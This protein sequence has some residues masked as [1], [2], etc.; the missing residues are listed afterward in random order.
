MRKPTKSLNRQEC[1]IRLRKIGPLARY[2]SLSHAGVLEAFMAQ[3][4]PQDL[5]RKA[6]AYRERFVGLL[7]SR[8]PKPKLVRSDAGFV[9]NLEEDLAGEERPFRKMSPIDRAPLRVGINMSSD[10]TL[11]SLYA[12]RQGAILAIQ[13]LAR[14]AGRKVTFEIVYGLGLMFSYPCHVRVG[15]PMP[16]HAI[17]GRLA[18]G[19]TMGVIG[20]N[21]V[22]PL[23]KDKTYGLYRMYEFEADP[24]WPRE[25]DIILDRIEERNP[26]ALFEQILRRLEALGQKIKA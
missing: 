12:V 22:K 7:R 2:S 20:E 5:N 21:L 23:T 17:M 6:E 9:Y 19:N 24:C 11:L 16:T 10:Y 3:E 1:D 8:F 18:E 25:F 26:K 13:E 14:T 15:I 4:I